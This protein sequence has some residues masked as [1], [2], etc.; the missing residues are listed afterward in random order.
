MPEEC[1]TVKA[2][3][4]SGKLSLLTQPKRKQSPGGMQ[5]LR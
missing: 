1:V 3:A 2:V 5:Q 4:V